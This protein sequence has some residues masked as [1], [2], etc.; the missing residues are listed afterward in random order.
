[1]STSNAIFIFYFLFFIFYFVS[2]YKKLYFTAK[3][4]LFIKKNDIFTFIFKYELNFI[5]CIILRVVLYTLEILLID[6]VGVKF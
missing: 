5:V 2:F 1:M 3:V 6:N 4:I